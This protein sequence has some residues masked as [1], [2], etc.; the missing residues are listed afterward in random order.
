MGV[1]KITNLLLANIV[2]K[3]C[4]CY[5]C[6]DKPIMGGVMWYT[7]TGSG[8]RLTPKEAA[9]LHEVGVRL[10]D[11]GWSLRT[12]GRGHVDD[13]LH[14]AAE[15][16]G[17]KVMTITPYVYY[18]DYN[19]DQMKGVVYPFCRS[20]D[21][22]RSKALS[23]V[24]ADA[25]QMRYTSA[26]QR[27]LLASSVPMVLGPGLDEPSRFILTFYRATGGGQYAH[28]S[29]LDSAAPSFLRS[30]EGPVFHLA[31][32]RQIPIFNLADPEHMARIQN[33]IQTKRV[34]SAARA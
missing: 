4:L 27:D 21:L 15:L 24:E 26:L 25:H 19:A 2:F 6:V 9:I 5:G 12:G 16:S 13:I 22:L 30:Q 3:Q 11:D 7:G 17:G 28:Q 23:M 14:Q 18:R 20:P 8:A 33:F 32:R 10:A 31:M 1:Q 29:A 34:A